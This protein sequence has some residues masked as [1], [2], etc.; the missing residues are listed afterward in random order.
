MNDNKRI[1]SENQNLKFSIILPVYNREKI[2]S[3]SIKSILKQ[4]YSNW[5][6]IIVDDASV[7]GSRAVCESFAKI[8]SRIKIYSH[9]ANQGLSAA[10][11]TGLNHIEGDYILFLDDDDQ[12]K[13][14]TLSTLFFIC[15]TA[16]PDIVVFAI[17]DWWIPSEHIC[18]KLLD[19]EF[20]TK[21]ILPQH[22]NIC[23]H[24]EYFLQ[25][26][27]WHKC[28]RW[29]WLNENGIIFEERRRVWEDN[30]FLVQCFDK[31]KS[32][33]IIQNQLYIP[34]DFPSIDHLSWHVDEKVILQYIDGYKNN[35]HQFGDIYDFNNPYTSRR[36]FNVIN[37]QLKNLI[38]KVQ[39]DDFKKLLN[40]LVNEQVM[41]EWVV[42]ITSKDNTEKILVDAYIS[43]D[44]EGIYCILQDLSEIKQEPNTAHKKIKQNGFKKIL[45]RIINK[46]KM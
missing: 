20:I 46:L 14:N 25:T 27:V 6:L 21:N 24:T 9:A 19:K 12:F 34:G 16:N 39:P 41:Q 40:T 42:S 22:L 43:K 17:K 5:E 3:F 23:E 26:Y 28:Y 18:N 44:V 45:R 35:R 37:E 10:R 38:S 36:Y 4:D 33:Y 1:N 2:V 15:S 8:D 31:C 13:D 32:M 11:N 30:T 29:N 7:D